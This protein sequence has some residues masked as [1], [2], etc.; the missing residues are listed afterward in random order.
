MTPRGWARLATRRALASLDANAPQ[1]PRR[2][3]GALPARPTPPPEEGNPTMTSITDRPP[4]PV[5][6]DPQVLA[7]ASAVTGMKKREIVEVIDTDAGR[8]VHTVDGSACIIVSRDRPDGAGQ[9]GVMHYPRPGGPLPPK[10]AAVFVDPAPAQQAPAEEPWTI[11]DLDTAASRV[12]TPSAPT[13]GRAGPSYAP[14]IAEASD[15][16]ERAIRARALW[17]GRAERAHLTPNVAAHRF[18][19]CADFRRI[20][21]GSGLLSD[22]E[23]R[24]L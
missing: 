24:R 18:A 12:V 22:R 5:H 8:V 15:P 17:L 3:P 2:V 19:D 14:W 9:H 1:L 4:R 16:A 7:E 13:G 6:I 11:Q 20:V 21:I 10:G 23:A